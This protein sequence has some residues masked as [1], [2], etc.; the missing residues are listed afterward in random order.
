MVQTY[1]EQMDGGGHDSAR[2]LAVLGESGGSQLSMP[3][4]DLV[5]FV[6]LIVLKKFDP[7]CKHS[8]L[9]MEDI[10]ERRFKSR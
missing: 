1:R 9:K 7:N 4:S 2:V 6:C 3:K 10:F 8:V 5:T